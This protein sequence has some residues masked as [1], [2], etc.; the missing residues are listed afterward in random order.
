MATTDKRGKVTDENRAEAAALR[1]I[2]MRELPR[3]RDEGIGT[4]ERFGQQFEI[5]NQAAVGFF[6]NGKTAL[7]LKAAL[8]FA[9]GL[10]CSVADFSQRLARHLDGQVIEESLQVAA[11]GQASVLTAA[12]AAVADEFAQLSA[13]QWRMVA[14]RL[15]DLPGH[16]E[17][18]DD[19]VDDVLLILAT[20]KSKQHEQAA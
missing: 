18:R 20:T 8:G 9:K 10:R 7:S 6:L 3:L 12:L 17:M 11:Q 2:W 15:S 1:A 5:G 19:V 14:A 13:G 4:Q 16:P